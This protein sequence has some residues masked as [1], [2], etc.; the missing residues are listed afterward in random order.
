MMRGA[1]HA[2]AILTALGSTAA[3][4]AD[5]EATKEEIK[6]LYAAKLADQNAAFMRLLSFGG[7]A[8]TALKEEK[9]TLDTRFIELPQELAALKDGKAPKEG[10]GPK[11]VSRELKNV[12]IT[13]KWVDVLL[14]EIA[15]LR[16]WSEEVPAELQGKLNV[17]VNLAF[18]NDP[19]GKALESAGRQA[20]A[21][22]ALSPAAARIH[23]L[24]VLDVTGT[25][26]L[27]EFLEWAC[28]NFSLRIGTVDGKLVLAPKA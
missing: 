19:L 11:A 14:E 8:E 20:G 16:S 24:Q 9:E 18:R 17:S 23:R 28:Q 22:V 1:V 27:G 2:A 12:R 6:R 26:S 3:S 13:K 4:A 21:G 7:D 25:L 10:R 5:A 15:A